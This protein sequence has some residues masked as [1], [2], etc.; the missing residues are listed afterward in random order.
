[1]ASAVR[2]QLTGRERGI[3][4]V[5][6]NPA[7]EPASLSC[8]QPKAPQAALLQP[9]QSLQHPCSSKEGFWGDTAHSKAASLSLPHRW[10]PGME[11]NVCSTIMPYRQPLTLL[12]V[13]SAPLA[14]GQPGLGSPRDKVRFRGRGTRHGQ[15]TRCWLSTYRGQSSL[16]QARALLTLQA[17]PGDGSW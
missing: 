11:S 1:M 12:T 2:E 8:C 6:G 7:A 5:L 10:V 9:P 3:A 16:H 13:C 4:G 15:S 14:I 17:A